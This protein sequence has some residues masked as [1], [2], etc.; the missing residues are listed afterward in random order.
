MYE[1]QVVLNL[2]VQ[3]ECIST[4]VAGVMILFQAHKLHKTPVIAL[5]IT[6]QWIAD[7]QALFKQHPPRET[8]VF[9]A[10]NL[11]LEIKK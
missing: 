6:Q 8:F 9:R 7:K 11:Y 5:K 10:T 2:V 1:V 4:L 3:I